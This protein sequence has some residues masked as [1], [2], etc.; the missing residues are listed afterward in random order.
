MSI[1]VHNEANQHLHLKA[2]HGT[3]CARNIQIVTVEC[4]KLKVTAIFLSPLSYRHS[5]IT[6]ILSPLPLAAAISMAP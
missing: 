1:Y 6:T 3:Q 5:P 2:I 4:A